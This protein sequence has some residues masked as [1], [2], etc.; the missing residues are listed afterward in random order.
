[1][2]LPGAER[3]IVD[4]AKV[5]DYLLSA[6]HPVGRSKAVF[7]NA[8]GFARDNWHE[9]QQVITSLAIEDTAEL[10]EKIEFGQKY[11]VRGTIQGPNGR[12]AA[13]KTAWIVLNGEDFPRF[14]T[15]FPGDR[16]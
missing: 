16:K 11:V 4:P 6:E 3:A 12:V 2:K 7:F 8:L 15:A 13:V 10:G 1:V 14:V 9:L 5:R